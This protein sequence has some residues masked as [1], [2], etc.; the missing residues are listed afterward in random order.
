MNDCEA[1]ESPIQSPLARLKPYMFLGIRNG[2]YT[3]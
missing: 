3:A 1:V 2:V